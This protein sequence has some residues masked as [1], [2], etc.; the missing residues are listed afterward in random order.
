MKTLRRKEPLVNFGSIAFTTTAPP[1]ASQ[2]ASQLAV[3][4]LSCRAAVKP[5]WSQ[6]QSARPRCC[7]SPD[8]PAT[9]PPTPVHS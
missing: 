2:P 5:R 1:P 8:A 3:H 4:R 6:T 9:G 7:C